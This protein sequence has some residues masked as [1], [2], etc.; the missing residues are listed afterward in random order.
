MAKEAAEP[1]S[2]AFL[3]QE[4]SKELEEMTDKATVMHMKQ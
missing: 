1:Y 2:K 3:Q 4:V